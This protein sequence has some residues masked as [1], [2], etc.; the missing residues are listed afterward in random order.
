MKAFNYTKPLSIR[1]SGISTM[2]KRSFQLLTTTIALIFKYTDI[3]F[4]NAV[5]ME[6]Q[7]RNSK[8]L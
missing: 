7:L 8:L 1:N 2:A 4:E 6:P 3:A 5:S